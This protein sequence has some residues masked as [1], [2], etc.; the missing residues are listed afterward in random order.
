MCVCIPLLTYMS[1]WSISPR[2]TTNFHFEWNK[3]GPE[4]D[5]V[6]VIVAR[7][8]ICPHIFLPKSVQRWSPFK[9]AHFRDLVRMDP[10][11]HFEPQT[12]VGALTKL[13]FADVIVAR[14]RICP[15]YF[16]PQKL[17]VPRLSPIFEISFRWT[18]N[19]ILSDTHLLTSLLQGP[20][21][22][23][24]TRLV[25]SRSRFP[26]FVLSTRILWPQ[27]AASV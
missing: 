1:E 10:E 15:P 24:E 20:E 3:I 19:F 12:F 27:L 4:I 11:F 9:V 8:Q 13:D 7:P 16:P 25:W 14:P 23:A 26:I 6:D 18:P 5:I 22:A 17:S 2:W 21:F